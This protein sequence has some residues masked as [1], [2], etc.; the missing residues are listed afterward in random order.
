[1]AGSAVTNLQVLVNTPGVEKLPK[2]ASSLKRLTVST[3]EAGLSFTQLS[4]GLKKQQ[5]EGGKSINNTRSLAN[6][7]KELAASV[8][9]GSKEFEVATARAKQLNA[10]LVKMEGRKGGGMGRLARTAGAVAGAGVFGGPE[11]AIGAA[12]GGL[13][14][15][16]G[17]ISA[18]VGGAIGAQVGMVR[19]AIG[20]T[21]EYSAALA[22]PRNALRLGIGDTE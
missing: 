3:K 15:G 13:M 7:W 8:K 14:P 2:L 18:A 16:G 5:R 1:M 19:Q 10:Q 22:R 21:A 17:P 9:F 20:S 4:V 11:G 6:A 12:I